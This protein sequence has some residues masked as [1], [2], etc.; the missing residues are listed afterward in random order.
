MINLT[1]TQTDLLSQNDSLLIKDSLA[2]KDSLVIGSVYKVKLINDEIAVGKL[3]AYDS[4]YLW[5]MVDESVIRIKRDK[6]KS[7]KLSKYDYSTKSRLRNTQD[8]SPYLSISLT[9]GGTFPFGNFS[10]GHDNGWSIGG[11]MSIHLNPQWAIYLN[12]TYNSFGYQ[13]TINS[14]S[15]ASNTELTTGVRSYFSQDE[16]KMFGEAG[17]GLYVYSTNGSISS[18]SNSYF[19][20]NFGFGADVQLSNEVDL[21][22]KMNYH[23]FWV[24]KEEWFLFTWTTYST[25]EYIG[26][27][28]GLKYNFW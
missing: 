27:K 14:N 16:I 23:I 8:N 26:F 10:H 15:T 13:D 19:G 4:T 1:F 18:K 3:Q 21:V 11:D 6:I 12:G 20:M 5:L 2:L 22:F 9:G 24:P 7:M 25:R 28:L 17:L